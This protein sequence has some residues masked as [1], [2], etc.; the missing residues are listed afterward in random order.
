MNNKKD[1]HVDLVFKAL[2]YGEKVHNDAGCTYGDNDEGYV[3]HL[4]DVRNW[5]LK[6]PSVLKL[7]DDYDNTM[8]AAFTHDVIEDTQQTYNDVM[9]ATNKDVA[10]ITMAITDVPAENR[11]LRFLL[12]AP[13]IIKD[14]RALVLK[15]CDIGANSSYG[16]SKKNSMY[17]KYKKEWAGYKRY[18]FVN[19]SRQYPGK[20]NLVEFNKLIAEVDRVLINNFI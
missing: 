9:E 8:A 5:M 1:T 2:N 18:I 20:L 19:A 14:Y 16:L 17:R 10:D 6:F 15:V 3:V 7:S 12:T 11:M 13:K 4:N